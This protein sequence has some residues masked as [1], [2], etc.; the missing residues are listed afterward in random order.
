MPGAR[1]TRSLACKIKKHT[2]MVTTVTPVSPDIPRAMVYGLFRALPGDQVFLTPSSAD[3]STDLTPTSRRQDHT[4]LP[5]ASC[6]SSTRRQSVHRN[7]V[8]RFV[9]SRAA[10][11]EGTGRRIDTSEIPYSQVKFWNKEKIWRARVG[12]S[13]MRA[14]YPV[15]ARAPALEGISLAF[16]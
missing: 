8:P 6:A 15:R 9:T 2:S 10:P 11:L 14:V 7:P 5:S 3:N 16:N 13:A 12:P 1:C 4:T